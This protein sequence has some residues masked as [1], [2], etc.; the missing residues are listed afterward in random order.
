MSTFYCRQY[1]SYNNDRPW[2]FVLHCLERRKIALGSDVLG[3]TCQGKD[4][5]AV[6]SLTNNLSECYEVYFGNE[7]EMPKCSCYDWGKTGY[8]C[9]FI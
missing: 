9:M 2:G 7:H 8:L 6:L 4:L 1:R 5:F 3:I